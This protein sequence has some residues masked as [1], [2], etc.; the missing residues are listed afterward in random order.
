MNRKVTDKYTHAETI[1]LTLFI[2]ITFFKRYGVNTGITVKLGYIHQSLSSSLM[3][4]GC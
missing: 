4:S 2:I 3:S 1:G